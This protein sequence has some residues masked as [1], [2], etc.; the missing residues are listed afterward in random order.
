[1]SVPTAIALPP[2]PEE[3]EAVPRPVLVDTIT[4]LIDHLD[5]RDPEPDREPEEDVGGDELGD[6]SWTEWQSR[7]RFKLD[8]GAEPCGANEDAEDDD[9]A[10]ESDPA[11]DNADR[12]AVDER[13]P[14][15]DDERET[16]A[17][18]LDHPAE[19]HVGQRPGHTTDQDVR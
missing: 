2:L 14:D 1:M 10:E 5:E 16:W 9:P 4:R 12:E 7:G 3:L 13:E 17:H 19:L 11:E 8:R 15:H 18:W 6:I